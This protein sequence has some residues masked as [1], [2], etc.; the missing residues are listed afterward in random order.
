MPNEFLAFSALGSLIGLTTAVYLGTTALV[1]SGF[2]TAINAKKAALIIAVVLALLFVAL[3]DPDNWQG[4]VIGLV[5]AA[6]AFLA[7]TGISTMAATGTT[8]TTAP[9][10]S[11]AVPVR[12]NGTGDEISDARKASTWGVYS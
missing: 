8:I 12:V 10:N 3:T 9:A 4:Y 11:P 2:V 1:A 7:A 5:N 6:M